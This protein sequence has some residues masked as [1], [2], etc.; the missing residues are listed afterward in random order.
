MENKTTEMKREYVQFSY[1]STDAFKRREA[2]KK[3]SEHIKQTVKETGGSMPKEL[4]DAYEGLNKV[5][6]HIKKVELSVIEVGR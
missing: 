5:F 3:A 2:V 1:S 6:E 4:I